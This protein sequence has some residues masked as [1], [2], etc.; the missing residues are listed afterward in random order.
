MFTYSYES[1][2]KAV[3]FHFC[4]VQNTVYVLEALDIDP[5]IGSRAAVVS[6]VIAR[7]SR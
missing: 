7:F 5:T 3:H 1:R 6:Q 4:F 2:D